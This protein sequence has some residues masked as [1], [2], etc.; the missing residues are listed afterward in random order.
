MGGLT[1]GLAVALAVA[2]GG[3]LPAPAQT[4]ETVMQDDAELLHRSPAE[5]RRSARR[6]A[7]I[8]VDRV[9]L[10]ASWSQ[11]APDSESER[12]PRFDG[13]NSRTYPRAGF[14]RL[15]RAVR[16]VQ[17]AGMK[18][19]IDIAF[20]A[21]RWAVERRG[22]A[23][24]HVWRPSPREFGRFTRALAERYGGVFRDPRGL[25][26]EVLPAVRLWTTWNEPNH[27]A[28]L[29]PQWELRGG[30]WRPA[31]PHHYRQMHN[32]A[33]DELK[34]VSPLNAVLIG[35][36]AS[37]GHPG[38]G[39]EANLGP[40]RFTRELA[41]VDSRMRPLRRR[42]CRG[43]A[44]LRAD[45]FAHHPYSL[46][47][48]PDDRDPGRDRVQIGEL[49]RLTGLLAELHR[50][51]RT[52]TPLP[53]Y[54]TE[55]GYETNPPDPRG[56]PPEEHARFLAHATYLAWSRPEVR[57]FSQFLLK[58]IGP[59]R[60]EPTGSVTRWSDYQSGLFGHEGRPKPL[61][62]QAFRLPFHVEALQAEDGSHAVI[63]F[64]QVRP[65]SGPQWM[66]IQR[67]DAR[68]RW[69]REDSAA[70][71]IT[72]A[73]ER[74]GS[75]ATDSQ[76]FYVRR[77]SFRGPGAYRAVWRQLEG[78]TNYSPSISVGAPPPAAGAATPAG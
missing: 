78:G 40:L 5:V 29:R 18:A 57:M 36:L 65:R 66:E 60:S 43:F 11:L 48:T 28:F 25:R 67:R 30:R 41:C 38:K 15:D 20:F 51:G 27:P 21:P 59:N 69:R 68:G 2:S 35:G 44:P 31:A 34:A 26:G 62:L 39:P 32:V 47:T 9:R 6:M 56:R 45:G 12:R 53:L 55:Y 37:F 50:L 70:A 64:G 72:S 23:G 4:R 49:D 61:V 3:G 63:A 17:A 1:C 73:A 75:F 8:G 22:G 10:T 33:Y 19:M 14:E 42:A 7:A 71:S 46:S 58:D 77:L 54:L 24:R 52:A 74:C 76:G 13:S 16:E